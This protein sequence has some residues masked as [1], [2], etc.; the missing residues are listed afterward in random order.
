M[1]RRCFSWFSIFVSLSLICSSVAE[2]LFALCFSFLS[3]HFFLVQV[4]PPYAVNLK[5]DRHNIY[6]PKSQLNTQEDAEI[7]FEVDSS[8]DVTQPSM[9]KTLSLMVGFFPRNVRGHVSGNV[10]GRDIT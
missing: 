7:Q 4:I 9:R 2:A 10:I 3:E 1:A 8:E 5:Y 6:H